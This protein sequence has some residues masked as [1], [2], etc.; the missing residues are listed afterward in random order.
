MQLD[1]L[2]PV[3]TW[4]QSKLAVIIL[5]MN[6]KMLDFNLS[7]EF[8]EYYL[9]PAYA[10]IY[11]QV[12][13]TTIPAH[14]IIL[15][16]RSLYFGKMVF[17]GNTVPQGSIIPIRNVS[18]EAFKNILSYLYRGQL[19]LDNLDINLALLILDLAERYFLKKIKLWLEYFLIERTSKFTCVEF[20]KTSI[21][22]NLEHLNA[23]CIK[24]IDR[25]GSFVIGL[26]EFLILPCNLFCGIVQRDSLNTPEFSVLEA[27][28]KWREYH[29]TDPIENFDKVVK[30]VRFGLLDKY[31]LKCLFLKQIQELD[32]LKYIESIAVKKPRFKYTLELNIMRASN[33]RLING[34]CINKEKFVGFI[35]QFN[36]KEQSIIFQFDS[37]YIV[38]CLDILI[39]DYENQEYIY[40]IE[41]SKDNVTWEKLCTYRNCTKNVKEVREKELIL[42]DPIGCRYLKITSTRSLQEC[43]S[44]YVHQLAVYF[45][46]THIKTP[47]IDKNYFKFPQDDKFN[48]EEK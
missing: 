11:F 48:F 21:I 40:K 41:G 4:N 17:W 22:Y 44:F 18:T 38:N 10:D 47:H 24:Y 27:V 6:S 42:K 1:I 45:R 36:N 23:V 31:G 25:Y 19:L 20:L 26:S 3:L 14:R 8:E 32:F 16:S 46:D 13:G 9:N 12:N 15:N 35:S 43:Q 2:Q 34:I 30:T 7:D 33:V 37:I 39:L 28:I 29:K 5:K